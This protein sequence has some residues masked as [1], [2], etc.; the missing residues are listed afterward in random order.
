MNFIRIESRQTKTRGSNFIKFGCGYVEGPQKGA[1]TKNVLNPLSELRSF[2]IFGS[3]LRSLSHRTISF[4]KFLPALLPLGV[5]I[6]PIHL[7]IFPVTHPTLPMA[8]VIEHITVN[9]GYCMK[10]PHRQIRF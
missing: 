9:I 2:S 7:E 10:T 6:Q 1:A 3:R 8:Y 4:L 5:L